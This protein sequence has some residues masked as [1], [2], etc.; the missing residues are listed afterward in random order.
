MLRAGEA[1]PSLKGKREARRQLLPGSGL[2]KHVILF[3]MILLTHI[4]LILEFYSIGTH[5]VTPEEVSSLMG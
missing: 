4:N 5:L 3:A 2:L 1:V